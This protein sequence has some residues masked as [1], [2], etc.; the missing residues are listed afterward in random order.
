MTARAQAHQKA[1][2][3]PFS[4]FEALASPTRTG[5]ANAL[6]V[7]NMRGPRHAAAAHEL[8]ERAADGALT[9][10]V[11]GSPLE[12]RQPHRALAPSARQLRGA[13]RG[14][15][16]VGNMS[17]GVRA[18][19]RTARLGD[20]I[21][22]CIHMSLSRADMFGTVWGAF[23]GAQFLTSWGAFGTC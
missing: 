22:G 23:A 5:C 7:A 8:N 1:S 3:A 18:T 20:V 4:M 21:G 13:T 11:P 19:C 14:G 17:D 10:E 2:M 16:I 9:G 6:Y 12:T 15:N